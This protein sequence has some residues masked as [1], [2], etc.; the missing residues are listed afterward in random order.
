M[1]A[2]NREDFSLL[3]DSA[4]PAWKKRRTARPQYILPPEQIQG[5]Q[6][7]VEL[8]LPHNIELPRP[9]R[10]FPSRRSETY[11]DRRLEATDITPPG[12]YHPPQAAEKRLLKALSSPIRSSTSSSRKYVRPSNEAETRHE[13]QEEPLSFYDITAWSLPVTYGLVEAAFAET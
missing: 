9:R 3:Y 6:S 7:L 13:R 2:D 4:K 12:P 5:G 11:F 10:P 1:L 8:C